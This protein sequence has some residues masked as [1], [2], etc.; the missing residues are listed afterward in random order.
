MRDGNKIRRRKALKSIAGATA[1]LSIPAVVGARKSP[2]QKFRKKI[3]ASHRRR[4]RT[5]N[6]GDWVQFLERK[7]LSVTHDG[8]RFSVDRSNGPTTQN[9][10]KWDIDLRQTLV[11]DC[12][13]NSYYAEIAFK[14]D[15]DAGHGEAPNDHAGLA[16]NADDWYLSGSTMDEQTETSGF[17]Y[18]HEEPNG[19]FEGTGAAFE[20]YDASVWHNGSDSYYYYGGVYLDSG[21]EKDSDNRYVWGA[22]NHN[23]S[24]TYVVVDSVDTSG[25]L[26]L[27]LETWDYSWKN[28]YNRAGD[29]EHLRTSE[30]DADVR[31][32]GG[33]T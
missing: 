8:G 3:Q 11:Y 33:I 31:N 26:T 15:F 14:Y 24:D 16:W 22:Y 10:S 29:G 6:F 20:V 21:Q 1:T 12:H 30:A 25:V 23:W 28:N 9:Y 17:V 27:S 7:G 5:G 13:A 2:K 4:D 19:S 32:C 18:L